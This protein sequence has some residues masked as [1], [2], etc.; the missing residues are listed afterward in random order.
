MKGDFSRLTFRPAKRYTS[1]RLQQ[2]R[3][4]LDSDWNEQAAIREHMER[5]RFEDVVGIAAVPRLAGFAV[6]DDG[7]GSLTLSAGRIYVG[8]FACELQE[9]APLAQLLQ[10]PATPASA[11]TDLVYLDAWEHHLTGIDDPDLLEPAL[12]G[13]DTTTRLKVVWGIGSVEDVGRA[14]CSE[15][16]SLLPQQPHGLMRAAAPGGYQGIENQLYRVEIHDSGRLGN[17]TFKW[18]RDN[19]SV[20]FAIREFLDPETVFL[21]SSDAALAL[22]VGD[23]VEVSG[24]ELELAV[25]TG[26][27][28]SIADV[29]EDATVVFDRDVS[30]H[31]VEKRPRIR[32]W[33]QRR[34]P[35]LPVTT[36]WVELEAGIEV[37]FSEGEFRSGD[38]WTIPA[39]PGHP[40][41]RVVRDELPHGIEHRVSPLALVT[42]EQAKNGWKPIIQ[43]CRRAFSSLTDVHE[44]LA[45]LT[46]EVAELRSKLAG[47]ES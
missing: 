36:D 40:V 37:R 34:G 27:L 43:D 4:T 9:P 33:D 44:Q 28:A 12:G 15:A 23:W 46:L 47:S 6:A 42:W 2:G 1:V 16:A 11:R 30:R 20:V 17:A 38:Y 19:G 45:R 41:D 14:S 32:R 8:G 21:A 35:T 5:A 26:T 22:E 24:E 39:R 18:S 13:A 7:N 31:R 10:N 3:V 25:A 29:R